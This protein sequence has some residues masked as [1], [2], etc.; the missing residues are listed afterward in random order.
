MA[1]KSKLMPK[2]PT[3]AEGLQKERRELEAALKAKH[4]FLG[5]MDRQ[6]K[7]QRLVEV[8]RRLNALFAGGIGLS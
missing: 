8:K 2:Q 3:E 5:P 1:K 4:S 7:A 6:A